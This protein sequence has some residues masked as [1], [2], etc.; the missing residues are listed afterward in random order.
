MNNHHPLILV[1][2][3]DDYQSK[4]VRRS[5]E[6]AGYRIE[7]AALGRSVLEKIYQVKPAL[8]LLDWQL[9]DL[10]GLAVLRMIRADVRA[11]RLPLI[12]IGPQMSESDRIIAL[13]TGA[14]ICLA[15]SFQER[16][17]AARVRALLRRV[18]CQ[19]VERGQKEIMARPENGS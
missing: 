5:L 15:E 3:T 12:L 16:V 7:R 11:S 1:V 18:A 8:V 17:I 4:L 14:D 13:E 19:E 10:S 9:P 2:S 6:L